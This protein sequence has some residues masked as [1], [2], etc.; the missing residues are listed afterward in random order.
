MPLPPWPFGHPSVFLPCAELGGWRGGGGGHV[1]D[2]VCS[3]GCHRVELP[4]L[5]RFLP[6]S[7][8]I[9]MPRARCNEERITD[10][11]VPRSV[12]RAARYIFATRDSFSAE[13]IAD[14]ARAGPLRPRYLSLSL[15][16]VPAARGI[17]GESRATDDIRVVGATLSSSRDVDVGSSDSISADESASPLTT[18]RRRGAWMRERC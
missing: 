15:S 14:V 16:L 12:D 3:N 9:L 11:F 10:G 4:A 7:E 17:F 13:E 2:G 18:S 8:T 1:L 6:T 5:Q